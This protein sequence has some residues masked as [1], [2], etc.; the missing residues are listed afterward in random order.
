MSTEVKFPSTT[1]PL[2][3]PNPK[4]NRPPPWQW[5]KIIQ[6]FS[7]TQNEANSDG[8]QGQEECNLSANPEKEIGGRSGGGGTHKK[9]PRKESS[10]RG[11]RKPP[12]RCPLDWG[13]APPPPPNSGPHFRNFFVCVPTLHIKCTYGT[14]WAGSCRRKTSSTW[15]RSVWTRSLVFLQILII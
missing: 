12:S 10:S 15:K 4:I 8:R 1:R 6:H 5:L 2:K 14:P 9:P 3:V 11:Q 13:G 7:E